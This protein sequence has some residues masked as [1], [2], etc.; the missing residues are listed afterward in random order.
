MVLYFEVTHHRQSLEKDY[1]KTQANS[2]MTWSKFKESQFQK[3][4]HQILLFFFCVPSS[5]W[6]K[7]FFITYVRP[8]LS[9]IAKLQVGFY[10]GGNYYNLES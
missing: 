2:S 9:I 6:E 4:R 8:L 3:A 5:T 1:K 10:I 7:Y